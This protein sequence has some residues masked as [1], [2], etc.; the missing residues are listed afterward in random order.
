MNAQQTRDTEDIQVGHSLADT[1]QGIYPHTGSQEIGDRNHAVR[2]T[3]NQLERVERS[4]RRFWVTFIV[5]FLGLQV[6]GGIAAI[7]LAVSDP[8]VAVIPNYY[9][10][11][12][13][14]D[15][16]RR[17]RELAQDL[18]WRIDIETGAIAA[19]ADRRPIEVR[20]LSRSG[21]AISGV[22]VSAKLYHHSR[23]AEIYQLRLDETAPG[24]FRGTTALTK[25]GVWQVELQV[26]GDHGIAAVSREIV[27]L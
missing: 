27:V 25:P 21:K 8:T 20:I 10:A 4:A 22:L 6:A 26:E 5:G 1:A 12:V 3:D 15:V 19:S 9:D 7:Y 11:A 2:R 16:T 18:G 24:V 14:W 17:A 23:G 13:N